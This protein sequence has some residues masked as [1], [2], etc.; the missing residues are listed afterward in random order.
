MA[1][2]VKLAMDLVALLWPF[3]RVYPWE[4]GIYFAFPPFA[5]GRCWE[6]GPG[7]KVLF[8]WFTDLRTVCVKAEV[9]QTPLMLTKLL[10]GRTLNYSA[11]ITIEV[12]D[13]VK[14]YTELGHWVESVIEI[15]SGVI[16]VGLHRAEPDR[17]EPA[18][19]KLDRV[20]EELREDVNKA[21]EPY[22]LYAVQLR[23]SNLVPAG[24]VR[25]IRLVT[26]RATMPQP[27]HV[28]TP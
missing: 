6:V 20:T 5:R 23:L 14:T 18:R 12:R 27:P 8:P 25:V 10:D 22:G 17:L 13:A 21:L 3:R 24:P 19:G 4:R 1:E 28:E 16:A 15:A 9:Y 11:S 2:L 26:D 7:L